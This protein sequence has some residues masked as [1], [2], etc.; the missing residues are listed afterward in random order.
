M[1]EH[2]SGMIFCR[3]IMFMCGR[4]LFC[5]D[6]LLITMFRCGRTSFCCDMVYAEKQCSC[7]AEHCSAEFFVMFSNVQVWQCCSVVL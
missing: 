5:C 1:E 2:C 6:M 3:V 4:A 7:V